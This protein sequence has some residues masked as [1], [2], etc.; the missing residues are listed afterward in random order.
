[1]KM[2]PAPALALLPNF[3]PTRKSSTGSTAVILAVPT[4]A[5]MFMAPA[6]YTHNGV[7]VFRV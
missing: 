3:A 1:M 5:N 4:P 6:Y 2:A 7:Q